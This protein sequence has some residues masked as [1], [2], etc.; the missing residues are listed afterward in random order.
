[1]P[2]PGWR[3]AFWSHRPW[4]RAAPTSDSDAGEDAGEIKVGVVG[5]YSGALSADTAIAKDVIQAWAD[6]VNADGGLDG[7][8]IK[9]Y[10]EDDQGDP[11]QSLK[12]VRQ[13]VEQEHV[14]AIVGSAAQGTDSAWG[15]YL[16]KAGVPHVGGLGA[17]TGS[18]SSPSYFDTSGNLIALFYGTAEAASTYGSGLAQLYC[19]GSAP[20]AS[21]VDLLNA[22]GE[23]LGVSVPY[24]SA[25]DGNAPDYTA[26][27]N[28][29]KSSGVESYSM[30]LT[31]DVLKRV[32]AQCSQ[33]GVEATVISQVSNQTMAGE[34]GMDNV[35]FV[36]SHFPFFDEST[37]ATKEFHD[38][39]EKYAPDLGDD[40]HPLNFIAPAVWVSGKLFEAAVEASDSSEVTAESVK[41]GLYALDGETLG[42]LSGPLTFS[43]DEKT[44][45]NC[46]F[47]YVLQDGE[48]S[49][50]DGVKA[51]CAP[52][53]VVDPIIAS[54]G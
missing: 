6:D 42:G 27:C 49:A 28:G 34:E 25:V 7:K 38:A 39:L 16:D 26:I 44:L 19:A 36:D 4:P 47:K 29:V 18:F 23:P 17:G 8:K 53:E 10:I 45:N 50:P 5:T 14:V 2:W 33:Q 46:Y 48:F 15:P 11:A 1:M 20:C 3:W 41:E 40:E 51:I 12:L 21:T 13:L 37:P 54:M 31:S 9:L 24:S 43:P 32:A 52:S 22:M 30:S 35:Q